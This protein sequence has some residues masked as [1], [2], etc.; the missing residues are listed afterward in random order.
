MASEKWAAARDKVVSKACDLID[1]RNAKNALRGAAKEAAK[2][3]QREN[4]NELAEA[5]EKFQK[6]N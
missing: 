2:S 3:K 5:V 1:S 4:E 6:E